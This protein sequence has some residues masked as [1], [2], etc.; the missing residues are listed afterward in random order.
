MRFLLRGRSR[1]KL[2]E[3][4]GAVVAR[5]DEGVAPGRAHVDVDPV[6]ML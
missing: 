6:S 4:A 3:V 2:R 1:E 5:I